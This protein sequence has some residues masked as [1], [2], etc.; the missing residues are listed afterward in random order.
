MPTKHPADSI[1]QP[2]AEYDQPE[3]ET[4]PLIERLISSGRLK[5]ATVDLL[6]LGRPPE[7]R[8][9]LSISEALREQR[10]ES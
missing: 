4:I 1:C 7:E 3:L 6:A 2:Q 9:D 10:S 8:L 5:P